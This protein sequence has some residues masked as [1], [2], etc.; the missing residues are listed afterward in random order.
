MKRMVP[1]RPS[2]IATFWPTLKDIVTAVLSVLSYFRG[3]E[4]VETTWGRV[5]EKC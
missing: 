2:A 1:I 5:V 4:A 3:R